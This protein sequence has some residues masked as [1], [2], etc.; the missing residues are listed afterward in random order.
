MSVHYKIVR[1]HHIFV[2]GEDIPFA[3]PEL[4]FGKLVDGFYVFNRPAIVGNKLRAVVRNDKREVGFVTRLDPVGSTVL[5][6]PEP[7]ILKLL[8]VD[9]QFSVF[10]VFDDLPGV[11]DII[12][13]YFMGPGP[14]GNVV[15]EINRTYEQ[16]HKNERKKQRKS[17]LK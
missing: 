10:I 1:H 8:I 16:R 3:K 11:V 13:V 7:E 15:S 5:V 14:F 12:Q 9:H 4:I 17:E 6:D 2:V